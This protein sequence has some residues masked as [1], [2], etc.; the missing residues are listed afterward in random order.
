MRH[1]VFGTAPQVTT[2]RVTL[3]LCQPSVA[4]KGTGW[5]VESYLPNGQEVI[6]LSLDG[7]LGG[8][9]PVR[10]DSGK[11]SSCPQPAIAGEMPASCH[12]SATGRSLRAL[13]ADAGIQ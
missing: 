7:Q 4:D 1:F 5:L 10:T 12:H 11:V 3:T 2:L 13:F 9:M 6:C 8:G